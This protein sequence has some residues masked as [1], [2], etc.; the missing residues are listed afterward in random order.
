M[1]PAE[2]TAAIKTLCSEIGQSADVN[3]SIGS[4][5]MSAGLWPRGICTDVSL[6]VHGQTEFE[7]AI[8][9]L[10]AKWEEHRDLHASNTTKGMALAIIRLTA[11]LGECTDA[12]LRCEFPQSDIDRYGDEATALATEMGGNGPFEIVRVASN[13][14]EAA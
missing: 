13:L 5:G 12:A 4:S 6:W 9:A 11:E 8:A 1:T 3:I 2:I 14:A 10:R 7:G